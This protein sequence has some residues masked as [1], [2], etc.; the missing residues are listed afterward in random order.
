MRGAFTQGGGLGDL[1]LGYYHAA[2]DG[3]SEAEGRALWTTWKGGS[4]LH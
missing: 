1:A 2:P 3:A 4:G